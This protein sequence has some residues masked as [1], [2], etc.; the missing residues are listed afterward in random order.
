MVMQNRLPFKIDDYGIRNS[1]DVNSVRKVPEFSGLKV[2]LLGKIKQDQRS[3][4]S[5][6]LSSGMNLL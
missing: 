2:P 3:L 1:F 5:T 4:F 6:G